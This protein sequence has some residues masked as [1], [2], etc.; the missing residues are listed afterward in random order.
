MPTFDPK[1][2]MKKAPQVRLIFQSCTIDQ[3]T[4]KNFSAT[5]ASNGS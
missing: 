4:F 5:F 3:I 1:K 2:L